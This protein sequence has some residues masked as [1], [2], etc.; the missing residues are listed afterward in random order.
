[1]HASRF[2]LWVVL[3]TAL[4]ASSA[5]LAQQPPVPPAG[6]VTPAVKAEIVALA[7]TLR[8]NKDALMKLKPTP[9]Q[10]AE[11]AAS[12]EDAKKLTTYMESV[13]AALPPNGLAAKPTQT[14]VFVEDGGIAGGYT[15]HAAHF[16][17]GVGIY[18][19]KYVEP[20]KTSGMAVDGLVKVNGSWIMIPKMWRAFEG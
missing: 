1:M 14:E 13:F 19:F 15:K 4:S 2:R 16:K 9:A 8:G 6:A 7:T 10:I 3:A 20:G 18:G 5:L 12:E 11:I 17:T